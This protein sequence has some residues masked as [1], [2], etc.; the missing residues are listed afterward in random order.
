MS[1]EISE[2]EKEQMKELLGYGSSLPEGKHSVHS[3][4]HNVAVAEDTTKLGYL[5]KEEIGSLQNPI[6]S[7]KFLAR[8]AGN[9]MN[10]PELKTFF[11]ACS[12]DGTSTSLSKDAMLLKLAVTQ[13]R[14]LAD[15]TKK[16]KKENSSWFKKKDKKEEV[17]EE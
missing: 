10:K 15:V 9:I 11:L 7:F 2:E 8:F 3:F 17:S 13:K 5:D 14:E 4:L 12:E 1:E 16:P 6:R